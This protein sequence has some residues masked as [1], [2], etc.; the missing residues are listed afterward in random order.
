MVDILQQ[1]NRTD[2]SPE[3]Y[4]YR[5]YIDDL[6][7]MQNE[8]GL[9]KIGRSVDPEQRRR[10]LQLLDQC[11]IKIVTVLAER[12]RREPAVHR[13]LRKYHIDGEWFAGDVVSREA[14]VRVLRVGDL[15]WPFSLAEA[16]AEAWLE[17]LF[18]LRAVRLA[19]KEYGQQLRELRHCGPGWNADS[20][21]WSMLWYSRTGKWP[22]FDVT[23]EGGEVVL[24]AYGTD[25]DV[26]I[27]VP[28]YSA[29]IE[30]ALTLW[31][32]DAA[33]SS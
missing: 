4:S 32:D 15:R 26:P 6:Y 16:A 1:E 29:E 11:Q 14:M 22:M 10:Q 19:E 8:H 12:G 30:L 23:H 2:A 17:R 27:R 5:V 31:P 24:D 3:S 20:R 13:A 7:V 33:L 28:H 21:I 18:D 25:D 9:I